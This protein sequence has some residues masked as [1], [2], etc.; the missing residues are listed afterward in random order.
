VVISKNVNQEAL[1]RVARLG[2]LS[3]DLGNFGIDGIFLGI[4]FFKKIL[5]Y[6]LGIVG[7]AL[8]N[9]LSILTYAKPSMSSLVLC[10]IF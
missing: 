7:T 2:I 6:I 10:L 3:K 8:G 9:C 4:Y 5:G 1:G